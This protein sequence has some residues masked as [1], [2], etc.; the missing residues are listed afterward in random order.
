VRH[1]ARLFDPGNRDQRLRDEWPRK[2]FGHRRRIIAEQPG[3]QA[4][5]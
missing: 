3:L 5:H 4:A 2:G 1:R